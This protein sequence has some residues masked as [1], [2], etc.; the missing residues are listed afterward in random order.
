[1]S[2][3]AIADMNKQTI[4]CSLRGVFLKIIGKTIQA[5]RLGPVATNK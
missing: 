3:Q 2:K 4:N 5:T 1:M